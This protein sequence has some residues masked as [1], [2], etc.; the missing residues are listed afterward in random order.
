MTYVLKNRSER[1]LWWFQIQK[2][3][4][5]VSIVDSYNFKYF[6]VVWLYRVAQVYIAGRGTPRE[7][8][9]NRAPV[10]EFRHDKGGG[11]RRASVWHQRD[12][13]DMI[14]STSGLLWGYHPCAHKHTPTMTPCTQTTWCHVSQATICPFQGFSPLEPPPS[15]MT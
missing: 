10:Y 6:S 5:L 11:I 14:P 4:T 15:L 12:P 13:G 1:N 3:T 7:A 9:H 2:T 8:S